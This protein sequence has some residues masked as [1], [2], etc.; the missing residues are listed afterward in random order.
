MKLMRRRY[1]M[2]LP[3]VLENVRKV[4]IDEKMVVIELEDGR[5]VTVV[6]SYYDEIEE[7]ESEWCYLEHLCLEVRYESD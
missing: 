6:P 5:V 7:C 1:A 3:Q 2:S 4:R